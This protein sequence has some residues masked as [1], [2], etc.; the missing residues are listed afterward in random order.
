MG[1]VY[2]NHTRS[3]IMTI[4]QIIELR[5]LIKAK[6]SGPL[7]QVVLWKR[8]K[9]LANLFLIIKWLNLTTTQG[10][11]AIALLIF[12]AY[13]LGATSA[14][15][16][17]STCPPPQNDVAIWLPIKWEVWGGQVKFANYVPSLSKCTEDFF[18]F[19]VSLM[20]HIKDGKQ[21]LLRPSQGFYIKINCAWKIIT[22]LQWATRKT[23]RNN[24]LLTI[25]LRHSKCN[26]LTCHSW[27]TVVFQDSK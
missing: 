7:Y 20:K 12:L 14:G 18:S 13:G 17:C 23:T 4:E 26:L 27:C 15:H 6:T 8:L 24:N 16:I 22:F 1:Q 25:L 21:T 19:C 2:R 3:D 5:K 11:P 9:Y 10:S